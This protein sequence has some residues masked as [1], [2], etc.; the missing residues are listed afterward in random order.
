MSSSIEVENYFYIINNSHT[1]K[2]TKFLVAIHIVFLEA[3]QVFLKKREKEKRVKCKT[4][5]QL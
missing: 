1:E 5:L 3:K 2:K 4:G